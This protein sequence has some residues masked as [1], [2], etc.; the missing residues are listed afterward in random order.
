MGSG[1]WGRPI[2]ECLRG[3]VVSGTCPPYPPVDR[4]SGSGFQPGAPIA[5]HKQTNNILSGLTVDNLGAL[6]RFQI[7]GNEPPSTVG[8]SEFV[9]RDE[10]YGRL[11]DI[12]QFPVGAG[13]AMA[14]QA[15]NLLT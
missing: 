7:E 13:I 8:A 2:G 14:Q 12:G 1:H 4:G 9:G 5:M 6:T 10:R 15:E 3:G 11:T